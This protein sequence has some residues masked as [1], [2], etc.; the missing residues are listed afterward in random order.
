MRSFLG[1]E[2]VWGPQFGINRTTVD[3]EALKFPT[4]DRAEAVI[5]KSF[6]DFPMVHALK[7]SDV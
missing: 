2:I 4:R 1:E 5:L 3:P 7:V 6:G